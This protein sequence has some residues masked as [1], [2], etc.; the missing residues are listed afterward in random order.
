VWRATDYASVNLSEAG[1]ANIMQARLQPG[2]GIE[3]GSGP[4]KTP[5]D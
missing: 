2:V 1:A 5:I 3:A 4:S